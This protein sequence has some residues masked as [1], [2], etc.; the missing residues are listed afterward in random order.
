MDNMDLLLKDA[1]EEMVTQEYENR[2]LDYPEHRFSL[3]FRIKMHHMIRKIG[4]EEKGIRDRTSILEL[5]R[6]IHSRRRLILLVALI[7]L[8]LGGTVVAAKTLICWLY[9]ITIEQRED[10]VKVNEDESAISGDE[11]SVTEEGFRKYKLTRIPE[12]Y[13]LVEEK[14]DAEF[15]EIVEV[16]ENQDGYL[17]LFK[18]NGQGEITMGNITSDR[19]ELEEVKVNGFKG[20][21]VEDFDTAS[22][23][24]SDGEELIQLFGY[25]TKEDLLA[26]AEGL[27]LLE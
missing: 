15:K 11:T 5:Y 8:L 10:H 20:F 21:Y 4:T 24:L 6:P 17:L 19:E 27:E 1:F 9:Q 3:K 23:I 14:I 22:L 13:N 7:L 16:Y 12:G 26:L 2:F 25:L 18:Q